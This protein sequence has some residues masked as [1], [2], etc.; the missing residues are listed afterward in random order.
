MNLKCERDPED[1]W[2][3]LEED[4]KCPTESYSANMAKAV[5]PKAR[6]VLVGV[7]SRKYVTGGVLGGITKL[8]TE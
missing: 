5:E 2:I 7:A 1:A 3:L 4:K 6:G 8:I